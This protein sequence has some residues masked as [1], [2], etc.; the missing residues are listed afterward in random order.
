[1]CVDTFNVLSHDP[2]MRQEYIGVLIQL[3]VLTGASW[4]ATCIVWLLARSQQW[5][6]LLQDA[7]KT[8][9]PWSFQHT[10]KI[11]MVI[12]C[13]AL[14]TPW[15]LS[16]SSQ[17]R[18]WKT[19]ESARLPW[20]SDRKRNRALRPG[21]DLPCCPSCQQRW[22]FEWQRPGWTTARR[23]SRREAGAT[24]RHCKPGRPGMAEEARWT[25]WACRSCSTCHRRCSAQVACV[26]CRPI[27]TSKGRGEKLRVYESN[28]RWT[29]WWAVRL[30]V[31][32]FNSDVGRC[33]AMY[34]AG[35]SV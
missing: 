10:S 17:Q 6:S 30:T 22:G 16:S 31:D 35:N 9:L 26:R 25:Q 20:H 34:E 21:R 3:Q 27:G 13:K 29:R 18:T 14:G 2:V 28:R 1:M 7:M 19:L 4:A 23:R 15:P 24:W 32:C 12:D 11:G 33:A 8:L 5:T